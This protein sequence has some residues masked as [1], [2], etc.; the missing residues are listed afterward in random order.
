[1]ELRWLKLDNGDRV[2]QYLEKL[3]TSEYKWTDVRQEEKL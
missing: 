2:L 1:M 3:N